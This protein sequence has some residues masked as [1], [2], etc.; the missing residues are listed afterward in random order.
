MFPNN[1]RYQGSASSSSSA[2][3]LSTGFEV[4]CKGGNFGGKKTSRRLL[5]TDCH[6]GRVNCSP[7]SSPASSGFDVRTRGGS[8]FGNNAASMPAKSDFQ[9]GT[10]SVPLGKSKSS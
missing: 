5:N 3:S 9:S 8:F 1:E 4:S 10:S 2:F 7:Q 6:Q